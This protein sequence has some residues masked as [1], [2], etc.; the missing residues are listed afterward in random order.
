MDDNA[1][2]VSTIQHDFKQYGILSIGLVKMF[3][4]GLFANKKLIVTFRMSKF[5][6]LT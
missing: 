4:D 2:L 5:G 3:H 6:Y 1:H